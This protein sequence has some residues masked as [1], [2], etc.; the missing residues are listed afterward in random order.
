MLCFLSSNLEFPSGSTNYNSTVLVFQA[1]VDIHLE[2]FWEL[3]LVQCV[4]H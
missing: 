4:A 3:V 1:R 2:D